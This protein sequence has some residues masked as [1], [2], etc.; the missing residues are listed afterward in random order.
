V[1]RY[2]HDYSYN[3]ELPDD[4]IEYVYVDNFDELQNDLE[5]DPCKYGSKSSD[6]L[7]CVDIFSFM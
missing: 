5:S 3:K 7:Y 6:V 4:G 1:F 2:N